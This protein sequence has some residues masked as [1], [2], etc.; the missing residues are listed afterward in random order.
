M[1]KIFI[2][3]GHGGKDLGASGNGL[4]EKNV[5]L[6]IAKQIQA[7]LTDYQ[8]VEVK[9]SRSDDSYLTLTERTNLANNWG[10]K[11]LCSDSFE[12]WWGQWI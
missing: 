12:F 1:P 3:P 8:D 9:M 10:G 5:A 11:L 2:D 6:D 4:V 7:M